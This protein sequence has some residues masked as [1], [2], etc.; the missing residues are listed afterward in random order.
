MKLNAFRAAL[1]VVS[2][3]VDVGELSSAQRS[4][5]GIDFDPKNS[6][7]ERDAALRQVE[8]CLEDVVFLGDANGSSK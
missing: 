1:S 8:Q 3:R 4:E 2:G 7:A 6:V 5:L